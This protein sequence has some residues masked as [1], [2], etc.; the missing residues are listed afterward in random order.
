MSY[1]VLIILPVKNDI[2]RLK[3]TLKSILTQSL[4]NFRL[5]II[6]DGSEIDLEKYIRNI[7]DDRLDYIRN[8]INM[9]ITYSLN[10]GIEK[11]NNEKYVA[12]AD[13]GDIYHKK[14]LFI[15]TKY[16][17]NNKNISVVSCFEKKKLKELVYSYI[18]K[19]PIT[20]DQI[21]QYFIFDSPVIHSS[22]VMRAEI[23]L[24]GIR[25]NETYKYGQ[26]YELWSRLLK[27]YEFFNVKKRYVKLDRKNS[28][29]TKNINKNKTVDKNIFKRNRV[30]FF[31]T[32]NSFN[33]SDSDIDYILFFSDNENNEFK[34]EI[35]SLNALNNLL[36]QFTFKSSSNKILITQYIK[37]YIENSTRK[38]DIKI[39]FL[40]DVLRVGNN[41]VL[42]NPQIFLYA[43]YY[44]WRL[45]K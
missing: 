25:Y 21:K 30:K 14:W 6:D 28:S 41:S 37:R 11:I 7:K 39:K 15:L 13:A 16:L 35:K 34:D 19:K 1:K 29:I 33:L 31:L 17:D 42:K 26:D 45:Q 18:F 8:P 40:K 10:K 2:F 20:H 9:G 23:F 32:D 44:K 12:R 4:S 43:L 22:V 36:D 5:L 27:R 3:K 24:S 38:K